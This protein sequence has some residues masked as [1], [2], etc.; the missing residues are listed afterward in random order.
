MEPA[1]LARIPA[2]KEGAGP[3]DR[4]AG[5]NIISK[6]GRRRGEF[7]GSGFFL[8]AG[9]RLSLRMNPLAPTL[10]TKRGS[11]PTPNHAPFMTPSA[12]KQKLFERI[13]KTLAEGK[14]IPPELNDP[15]FKRQYLA[16]RNDQYRR[17]IAALHR[18]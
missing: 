15:A 9:R 3:V 17:N 4:L 5:G 8:R 2:V 7:G 16:W 10:S 11:T 12:D 14:P 6:R 13:L 18:N 1:R